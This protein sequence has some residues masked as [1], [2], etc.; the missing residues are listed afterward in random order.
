MMRKS[1]A[2]TM[3]HS[4]APRMEVILLE[5]VC[6]LCGRISVLLLRAFNHGGAVSGLETHFAEYSDITLVQHAFDYFR[7]SYLIYL[8]G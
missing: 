8:K 1:R 7:G 2:Q 5:W 3:V 4:Y 6:S